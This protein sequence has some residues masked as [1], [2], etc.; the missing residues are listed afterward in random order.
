G[1]ALPSRPPMPSPDT[2]PDAQAQTGAP[3]ADSPRPVAR[4]DPTPAST[5]QQ[6]RRAKGTAGAP[7]AGGQ[8]GTVATPTL[9]PGQRQSLRAEWGARILARVTRQHHYP[10]GSR[11]E[12]RALVELVVAANGQLL[13]ARLVRSAGDASLDRAAL[14]AVR[15]AAPFPAAPRGLGRPRDSFTLPLN[16]ERR[17]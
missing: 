12:G 7:V 1:R 17:R 9:S 15:R 8:T 2:L 13:S 3:L 5:P 6:A 10:R 11:A 14:A 4:P 16:F